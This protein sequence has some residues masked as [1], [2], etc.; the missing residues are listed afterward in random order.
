MGWNKDIRK[1]QAPQSG[2]ADPPTDDFES[3]DSSANFTMK[4]YP[5]RLVFI[6]FSLVT[7]LPL[8]AQPKITVQPLNV[9]VQMGKNAQFAITVSGSAPLRYQWRHDG[10]DLPGETNRILNLTNVNFANLGRHDVVVTNTAGTAT[11]NPAWLRA[12]RWTELVV[13]GSSGELQRC[14]GLAWPDYLA[15]ELGIRLTNNAVGGADSTRLR[16][17]ISGFLS[18]NVLTTNMLVT[19]W[20]GGVDL[21]YRQ[22]S[23]AQAMS[24]HFAHVQRLAENGARNFLIPKLWPPELVPYFVAN[25]PYLT[26]Q[27]VADFDLRFDQNLAALQAEYGLTIFRPDLFVYMTAVSQNPAKFGLNGTV[28]AFTCDGLHFTTAVHRVMTEEL[29]RSVTPPTIINSG[30]QSA[31]GA[32]VLDWIGGSMP[33]CVEGTTDLGSG[34]WN[35]V[36]EVSLARTATVPVSNSN[37]FFRILRLG[38]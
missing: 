12:A 35:P 2:G 20:T 24:N 14:S 8:A 22:I 15:T 27:L 5:T 31:D 1:R 11:S 36:G 32:L 21:Y 29:S 9:S 33:F 23:A 16:S 6:A 37:H 19:L 30:N 25:A 17:Q 7:L 18:N 13:F 28:A 3:E 38:Q 10:M 34:Q 26:S 4:T